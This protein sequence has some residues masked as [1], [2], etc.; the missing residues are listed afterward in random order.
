M[1]P[2]STKALTKSGLTALHIAVDAYINTHRIDLAVVQSLIKADPDSVKVGYRDGSFGGRPCIHH[3]CDLARSHTDTCCADMVKELAKYH[4]DPIEQPYSTEETVVHWSLNQDL[5][6]LQ[7]ALIRSRGEIAK[8][9]DSRGMTLIHHT[10][11][12]SILHSREKLDLMTFLID[13]Y[14]TCASVQDRTG[15]LPLHYAVA[16]RQDPRIVKFLINAHTEGVSTKD[17]KGDIALHIAARDLNV[18]AGTVDALCEYAKTAQI[19][20]RDDRLPL[21]LAF[22]VGQGDQIKD[23]IKAAWPDASEFMFGRDRG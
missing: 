3:V 18:I 16:T 13:A 1:A 19:K 10:M 17:N 23:L 15:S 7:D 2:E 5:P 4:S 8:H 20:D 11:K 22:E 6:L 14:P 21:R 12:G 9:V